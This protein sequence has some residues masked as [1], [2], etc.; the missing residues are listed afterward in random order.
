MRDIKFRVFNTK[1][2][3]YASENSF[4]VV[5]ETTLFDI[6]KQQFKAE[7]L[8][9][10]LIEEYAG[11]TDCQGTE[12]YEGDTAEFIHYPD[13]KGIVRIDEVGKYLETP[14]EKLYFFEYLDYVSSDLRVTG[15]SHGVEW[16]ND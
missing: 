15:N 8:T 6:L 16:N 10:L 9:L 1:K 5:G 13:L 4:W 11:C 7:E 2:G 14:K 12:I 3:E